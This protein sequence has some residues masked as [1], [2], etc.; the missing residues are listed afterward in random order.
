VPL[1]DAV[2]ARVRDVL[3]AYEARYPDAVDAARAVAL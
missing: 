3:V 1:D 2:A